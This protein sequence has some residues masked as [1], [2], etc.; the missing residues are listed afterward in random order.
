MIGKNWIFIDNAI[1]FAKF[2][3]NRGLIKIKTI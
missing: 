3:S 2:L 1:K